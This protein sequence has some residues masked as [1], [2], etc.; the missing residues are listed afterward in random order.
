MSLTTVDHVA[1][2]REKLQ[3]RSAVIGVI[4]LGYVGLP[5]I[6]AFRQAGFP[7]MGFD[8][9]EDKVSRLNRGESYIAHIPADRIAAGWTAA[10]Q[11]TAD[12]SRLAE[13]DA[14]L[15]CV[16]TPLTDSRDPDLQLCRRHHR[17]DRQGACAPA[18]WS[19]WKARPT[20]A[21]PAT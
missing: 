8:V 19:C 21:R 10:V 18:N 12:M 7:M 11:A 3:T 2:L 5:L 9:D 6:D 1:A 20:P 14:L 15:I 13:A 4:G 17:G 16:P